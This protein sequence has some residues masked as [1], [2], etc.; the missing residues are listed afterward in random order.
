M[1]SNQ[2][3][4]RRLLNSL[5]SAAVGA[6]ALQGVKAVGMAPVLTAEHKAQLSRSKVYGSGYFGE[7]IKDE[8]GVP[9]YHYT[10]DQT[11]DPK[12]VTPG[13][14]WP[15]ATDHIHQVG[16][17]RLVAAASNYGYV[18]IRQDEGAPKFLNDYSPSR[19]QYGG[20]VGFL[21]AGK[22]FVSTFF[23]GNARLF[24]R[25]FG[26]GYFRKRVTGGNYTADQVIF[27]PFGDDP[28]VISQVTIHTNHNQEPAEIR[29]V[30]YWGCQLCQF[31][32]RYSME[33]RIQYALGEGISSELSKV[34]E[35]RRAFGDCFAQSLP[36]IGRRR[37]A[38]GD[39]A[40]PGALCRRRENVARSIV[41][42]PHA[43]GR[44]VY[45]TGRGRA[46]GGRNGG[47]GLLRQ[48]S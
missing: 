42:D 32:Y 4:R 6:L 37:G 2:L 13:H 45:R 7:W 28:L 12:A 15:S 23:P 41:A 20:G 16:N 35:L 34:A 27:A 38:P 29:W 26:I 48:P 17:D 5:G 24:D 8:F 30:E 47:P 31:S 40:V 14:V 46:A 9:A 33:V 22:E 36:Q 11:T 10:C 43:A 19:S 25:V 18:Q 39:E 44:V 21:T 1:Q 3:G